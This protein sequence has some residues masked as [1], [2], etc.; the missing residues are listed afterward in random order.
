MVGEYVNAAVGADLLCGPV[1]YLPPPPPG[2]HQ[3]VELS[4]YP[5]HPARPVP[6]PG[7][8][9]PGGDHRLFWSL[10]FAVRAE[11]WRQ[12]GGFNERYV[13]YGGEDTD[14][15]MLARAAGIGVSWVGG[16]AAYHQWHPVD[17][18]PTGHLADILRNGAVFAQRWGWWPMEGWLRQFAD[19]GLVDQAPDGSWTANPSATASATAPAIPLE[20]PR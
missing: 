9:M 3:L 12:I 13:G 8:V 15:A 17:A 6:A 14:F 1:A 10:S 7:S 18:P 2:G 4:R 11:Q 19:L 5:F 20:V 16:A